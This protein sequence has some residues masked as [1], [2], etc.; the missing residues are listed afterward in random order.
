MTDPCRA[1]FAD[2]D[3]VVHLETLPSRRTEQSERERTAARP[4]L[5][6]HRPPGRR[7]LRPR[8]PNGARLLTQKDVPNSP[9]FPADWIQWRRSYS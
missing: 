8:C 1:T 4:V 2:L 6:G 3:A 5:E 9:E 7:P